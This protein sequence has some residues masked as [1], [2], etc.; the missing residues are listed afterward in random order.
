MQNWKG[1]TLYPDILYSLRLMSWWVALTCHST[2]KWQIGYDE[3]L[4]FC[5]EGNVSHGPDWVPRDHSCYF[6]LSFPICWRTELPAECL[7]P[8]MAAARTSTSGRHWADCEPSQCSGAVSSPEAHLN[9]SRLV[10]VAGLAGPARLKVRAGLALWFWV[11][12]TMEACSL[13]T[14]AC[15]CLERFTLCGKSW[16]QIVA[17]AFFK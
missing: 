14:T 10:E 15:C 16:S 7:L 3:Q 2:N 4:E 12:P 1:L 8:P 11:I 9:R 6:F 17:L 5:I 13:D